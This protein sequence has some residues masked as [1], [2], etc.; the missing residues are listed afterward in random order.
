MHAGTFPLEGLTARLSLAAN[1]W[2][3]VGIMHID[4]LERFFWWKDQ[5]KEN[6]AESD[7]SE[8]PCT[9][10]QPDSSNPKTSWQECA[11]VQ[12]KDI[13]HGST[14]II[15]ALNRRVRQQTM[16]EFKNSDPLDLEQSSGCRSQFAR[17]LFLNQV[18]AVIIFI[19]NELCPMRVSTLLTQ[20]LVRCL[21]GER[22][23]EHVFSHGQM[24]PRRDNVL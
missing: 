8:R 9:A 22:Q 4:V 11:Q 18:R 13:S 19:V 21:K 17:C 15:K 10:Q 6:D 14:E 2:R 1:Q 24:T 5:T 23:E 7:G 3:T 20:R 16:Q 12:T